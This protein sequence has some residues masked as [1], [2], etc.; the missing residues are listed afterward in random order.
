[1]IIV[2]GGAGFIGSAFVWHLNEQGIDE[3]LIVDHLGTGDKWKNMARR[4][5]ADYMDKDA[6]LKRVEENKLPKTTQAVI[7]M[8]ACSSTTERDADYLM[9][10]NFAYTRALADWSIRNGVRFIY[11]S[12]GATYGDGSQGFRDDAETISRLFPLNMYGYSKQWFDQWAL[13]R[14]L[15]KYMVGLKFF[16]VYGPNEYHKSD[17]ASVVFKAFNQIREQ[18]RLSLFKSYKPEYA[19]G[20]QLRDFIYVKDVVRVLFDLMNRPEVN[21]I[22]NL[23]SGKARSWLDLARATFKAMDKEPVIDWIEMPETL[24]DRY[25]YFTQADMQRLHASMGTTT[26]FHSLEEGIDDYVRQYMRTGRLYL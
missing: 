26:A 17:M 7:H 3:I 24:R 20:E 11:A 21:G 18:G 13:Q 14:G 22:F 15:H 25:Q 9:R 4:R 1:M 10:N 19:D 2:T 12:S 16:N 6:F 23:G 8:G 5:F